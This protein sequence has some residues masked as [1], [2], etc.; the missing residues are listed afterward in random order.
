MIQPD[1]IIHSPVS[2][3]A[4]S[5]EGCGRV[6]LGGAS[7]PQSGSGVR[8]APKSGWQGL[9]RQRCPQPLRAPV[10][11]TGRTRALATHREGGSQTPR[12]LPAGV[13][14]PSPAPQQDWKQSGPEASHPTSQGHPV[15]PAGGLS[16]RVVC[17][18]VSLDVT[19]PASQLPSDRAPVRL[20]ATEASW[21]SE[22]PVS[23]DCA[24]LAWRGH[25]PATEVG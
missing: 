10:N 25:V 4:R 5:W 20:K 12:E 18:P 22:A 16:P 23:T 8:H 21:P 24:I 17:P 13:W 19:S 7:T 9:H 14:T 11:L 3:T 1:L 15:G 6:D 2:Q